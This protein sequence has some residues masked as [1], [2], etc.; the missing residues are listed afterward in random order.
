MKFLLI[1]AAVCAFGDTV[2]L[3]SGEKVEG[4]FLGGDARSIRIASGEKVRTIAISDV[5]SIRFAPSQAAA[6][7]APAPAREGGV[8]RPERKLTDTVAPPAPEIPPGTQIQVRMIDSVDSERDSVGAK[9]RASLQEPIVVN[10]K[11]IAPKGA[12]VT[13]VLLDN[14]QS[15]KFTGKTELTLDLL[16][17]RIGGRDVE[18]VSSAVT[19]ES[20]SQTGSTAKRTGGGA[21]L[22]AI[23]GAIAGGGKGAAIG[24]AAGGGAG[25]ASQVWT[26]GQR[27]RIPS[28]TR[29][30]F[31]LQETLKL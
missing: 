3:R 2:T 20:A 29:L 7:E 21:A 13:T 24:A 10:G 19:R 26:K 18:L 31:I 4:T 1:L 14:K 25:A 12:D 28:E 15:G 11:T 23:I 5:D 27:V 8:F 22:G 9:F 17:I 6:K 16:N 30:T